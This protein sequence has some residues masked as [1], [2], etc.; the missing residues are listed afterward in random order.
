MGPEVSFAPHALDQVL[1]QTEVGGKAAAGPVRRAI[2]RRA[3]RG[4]QY[5]GAY[6]CGQ[7]PRRTSRVLAR[8]ALHAVLQEAAA[9]LG[10]G[11]ARD[12]ELGGHGPCRNALG[13]EQ[14]DLGALNKPGR[15]DVRACDLFE[16]IALD[17]GQTNRLSFKWHMPIRRQ[18]DG[19]RF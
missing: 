18:P 3:A 17:G 5:S 8:Q 10:D 6:A 2:R 15:Q 13:E 14:H 7:L 19:K 16:L 4:G 9:P 11:R 12:V 1:R